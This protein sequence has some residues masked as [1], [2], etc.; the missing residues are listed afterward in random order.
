MERNLTAVLFVTN[1][2][3]KDIAF[4]SMLDCT[5]ER[6]L[7]GVHFVTKH[8]QKMATFRHM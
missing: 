3:Y 7:T 6:N 4:K 5:P 8:L 2:L 1:S